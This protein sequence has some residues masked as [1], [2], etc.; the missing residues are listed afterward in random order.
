VRRLSHWVY[1]QPQADSIAHDWESSYRPCQG[2]YLCGAGTHPGG[3]VIGA[4]GHNAAHAVIEDWERN[5]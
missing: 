2:L 1:S 4:P 5:A 3:E